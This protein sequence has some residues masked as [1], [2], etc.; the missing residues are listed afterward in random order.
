MGAM[1]GATLFLGINNCSTVQPVVSIERTVFYR[2]RGAGMYSAMPYAIAQVRSPVFVQRTSEIFHRFCICSWTS[3]CVH[4]ISGYF[5]SVFFIQTDLNLRWFSDYHRVALCI[6]PNNYIWI[7]SVLHDWIWMEGLQ[8]LMVSLHHVLHI[9]LLHILWY[10]GCFHHT[11]PSSGSYCGISFLC[12][13]QPLL[14]FLDAEAGK[15]HISNTTT[16]LF[17]IKEIFWTCI[18]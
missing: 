11:Q 1:Y 15:V 18:V 5:D 17:P 7:H 9:P 6:L 2:E 13:F 16:Y 8:V 4:T 3:F 10:D 14:R 12:N